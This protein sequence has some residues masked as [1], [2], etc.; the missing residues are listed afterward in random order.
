MD[1][2][3]PPAWLSRGEILKR[4]LKKKVPAPVVKSQ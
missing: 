4:K 2:Y 1:M 3:V